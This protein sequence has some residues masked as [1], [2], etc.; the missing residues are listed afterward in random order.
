MKRLMPI[1]CAA[2]CASVASPSFAWDGN[3]HQTVGAI[4]DGNLNAHARQQV[5]LLLKTLTLSDVG[6]WLDCAKDVPSATGKYK[7]QAPYQKWC[8]I[9]SSKKA[10]AEFERYAH[11]NWSNCALDPEGGRN[12]HSAYHYTDIFVEHASYSNTSHGANDHDLIHAINAAVAV[13]Q[14]NP[15]PL[16]FVIANKRIAL[17]MLA[18]LVGDLHQPL[19]VGAAYLSMT[20]DEVDPDAGTYDPA[21]FTQ[22]GNFLFD[23]S[24]KLHGEWDGSPSAPT[25]QE[26]MALVHDASQVPVT[27]GPVSGYAVAWANDSLAVAKMAFGG[28]SFQGSS[29]KHW[30]ISFADKS[31][32]LAL[33]HATQRDQRVKA[34]ARLAALLNAVWP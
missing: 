2:A 15:A 25:G 14:G 5:K 28:L 22:G 12:C 6:P 27:P 20:G 16:P 34:G 18:H 31:A 21:T 4:A 32:Y 10:A 11:A 24:K 7:A 1:M 17:L 13:L 33:L 3:G 8:G 23:G 26:L 29:P 19:H 9:F 30:T